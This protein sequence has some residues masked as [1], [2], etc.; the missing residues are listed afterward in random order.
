M[1]QIQRKCRSSNII[2]HRKC[3]ILLHIICIVNFKNLSV[4][5]L[6]YKLRETKVNIL[7][8]VAIPFP[9]TI[10]SVKCFYSFILVWIL[11]FNCFL[12]GW[13]IQGPGTAGIGSGGAS[14]WDVD[15]DM[16]EELQEEASVVATTKQTSDDGNQHTRTYT[17]S[18]NNDDI[19]LK[20]MCSLLLG[21][22]V[23]ERRDNC[24]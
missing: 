4:T 5:F 22:S 3:F 2:R 8:S 6:D 13:Q 19:I 14:T 12:S 18:G 17:H 1:W 11:C 9:P 16:Q 15:E 20:F 23:L 7:V 24:L 10:D 21:D